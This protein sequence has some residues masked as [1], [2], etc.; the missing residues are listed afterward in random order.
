MIAV[1]GAGTPGGFLRR[2]DARETVQVGDLRE[3]HGP[4]EAG[5]P[6]LVIDQLAHGDRIL[7]V[8]GELRPVLRHRLLVV[9][10]A[11]GD[12]GGD[13]E[14]RHALGGGEDRHDR[15]LLPRQRAPAIAE[16]G[17]QINHR[18][19]ARVDRYGGA[20]FPVAL[21]VAAEGV[22]DRSETGRD[23][24]VNSGLFSHGESMVARRFS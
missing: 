1:P 10:Q 19:L 15:V 11:L 7:A 9:E 12:R 13:G 14:G 23:V 21:E 18:A 5:Q 17:P 4:V 2:E 22:G 8:R 20:D 24:T 3:T 16:A 6:R